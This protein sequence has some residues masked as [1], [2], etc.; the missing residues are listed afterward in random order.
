MR[1]AVYADLE[2]VGDPAAV[3]AREAFA[4]FAAALR[5]HVDALVLVGRLD[6]AAP[7]TGLDRLRS[8]VAFAALPHYASLDRPWQAAVAG[9]RSL[10][11]F[12]RVLGEVDAVWLLGPHPLAL[13]FAMMAL[14]R[15]RRVVLGVREDLPAYVRLRRP[16]RRGLQL[17]ARALEAA[18]RAL[19]AGRPTAV[20]GQEL[21]R[22]YHAA[23]PLLGL[24][25]SLVRAVDV[26]E[27]AIRPCGRGEDRV[28]SV[29]RLDPEKNPLLLA[30]VLA[31]LRED[32]HP[33]RLVICGTGSLAP[34]LAS[35]LR[36]LGVAADAELLGHVERSRLLA[37]YAASDALLHVSWTEGVPQVLL[38]AFASG[39]PVVATDVGGVRRAA[40]DRSVLVP[41]GDAAAA[42]D[43]LRRVLDD[44]V[45]RNRLVRAGAAYAR[46]HTLEAET[47]RLAALLADSRPT[48]GAAAAACRYGWSWAVLP[49]SARVVD[50]GGDAGLERLVGEAGLAT[51]DGTADAVLLSA[52]AAGRRG[53]LRAAACTLAPHG[54]VGAVAGCPAELPTGPVARP[55]RAAQLLASP[56]QA[57]AARARAARIARALG[58]GGLQ[59][60][61]LA[62][63]DPR[64][65]HALGPGWWRGRRRA[66]VRWIVIGAR[67]R[68]PASTIEAVV[69]AAGA[70]V[71]TPL[72][73]ASTVVLESGKLR[74]D[75]AAPDGRRRYVVRMAALPARAELDRSLQALE[76]LA[77]T[78]AG[79]RIRE[80]IAWPLATGE[81]GVVRWS[82]EPHLAGGNPR[83]VD[84][85]LWRDALGFLVELHC[86]QRD[87]STAGV[88]AAA[89]ADRLA[90]AIGERLGPGAGVAVGR[91]A[92]R[93]GEL[94]A[95][96]P[97]GFAHGD[98]W[99]ENLLVHGGRLSTVLD[100]DWA[101]PRGLPVLDLM[102]LVT[103]SARRTRHMP[104]G[105]RF[106]DVLWPLG[107]GGGDRRIRE[108]CAATGVRLAGGALEA[109]AIAYWLDRLARDLRPFAERAGQP[110]WLD[111]NARAPL[112]ELERG[113]W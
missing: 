85:R 112:A 111:V 29:G 28:L 84:D 110:R 44:E 80:R 25:V 75:L 99:N 94:L 27:P 66:P 108:Y 76:A 31:R 104:L 36:E 2:Y 3:H 15:R 102:D 98:F 1:V 103:L 83:R 20:V 96:V 71:G 14:G 46:E 72:T 22:R 57:A 101:S 10:R 78:D 68:R 53:T 77:A 38:E 62:S 51:R 48:A 106:L 59:T 89:E 93:V 18:W 35:R 4:L 5:D 16:G 42:A 82:L 60:T 32:G 65:S 90:R 34:D 56:L 86:L 19:A 7:T 92:R 9:A 79:P 109:L 81:T 87:G 113:G 88:S 52:T 91:I 54:V 105:R 45:L 50:A 23:R 13:A 39:L 58:A 17:A 6:S 61:V 12:S 8:D 41:P 24:T 107:R 73:A 40:G 64:G 21:E 43:G 37:L 47:G 63:G 33:C 55:V 67:D 69:N 11:T 74:V 30:D 70:R 100:W 26:A 97:L 49:P 95:D